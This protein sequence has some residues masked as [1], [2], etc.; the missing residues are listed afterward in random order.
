MALYRTISMAFWTDSKIVDDFTPEDKYFYL[1]LFTNPHTNLCGCYE[2]SIKQIVNEIGYSDDSV[3]TLIRGFEEIH[4]VIRYCKETKE[5]LLLNWHKYNWSKSDKFLTAL[6]REIE[7]IKCEVFKQYYECLVNGEDT[8]SIR[9][10]YCIDTSN[11]NTNTNTITNTITNAYT[12][13]HTDAVEP[14]G[15][16]VDVTPTVTST[17]RKKDKRRYGEFNNVLLTDEEYQKLQSRFPDYKER[18]ESLSEYISSKGKKYK[19]HYAAIL[20]WAR[21]DQKPVNKASQELDDF[22]SMT[23]EWARSRGGG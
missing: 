2:I 16:N 10:P 7:G 5:I 4:K 6:R 3:R 18:I 21:K 1:Y 20:T 15:S 9:Y 17:L 12:V 22:Y 23:A 11:T 19:S 14:M 8:V 13:S